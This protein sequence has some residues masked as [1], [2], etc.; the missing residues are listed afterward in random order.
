LGKNGQE[1]ARTGYHR[2]V[3]L[4]A[5]SR[6]RERIGANFSTAVSQIEDC[7]HDA[8][9]VPSLIVYSIKNSE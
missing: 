4:A 2:V 5:A 8:F 7:P 1:Q 9:L 3:L 6:N